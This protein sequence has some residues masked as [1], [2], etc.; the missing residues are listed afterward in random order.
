MEDTITL[1]QEELETRIKEAVDNATKD[2]VSK[3]NSDMAK[4]RK[5]NTD[6]RNASKSQEQISIPNERLN[7]LNICCL[8]L[9]LSKFI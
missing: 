7:T 5:E 3:H 2:L 1:T 4:M 8:K 6:L 9:K